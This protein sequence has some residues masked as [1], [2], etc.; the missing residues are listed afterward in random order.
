[1][2]LTYFH[3][4]FFDLTY[5]VFNSALIELCQ[6]AKSCKPFF[7]VNK[8]ALNCDDIQTLFEFSWMSQDDVT[9]FAWFR[10][11]FQISPS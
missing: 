8:W 4:N 11:N 10:Y 7:L 3:L 5:L 1:M 2:V 9:F 6:D